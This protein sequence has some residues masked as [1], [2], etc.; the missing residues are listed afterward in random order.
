MQQKNRIFVFIIIFYGSFTYLWIC[1]FVNRSPR[2][3]QMFLL[4]VFSLQRANAT[5]NRSFRSRNSF[6]LSFPH[7]HCLNRLDNT[8]NFFKRHK[9]R[10]VIISYCENYF[11]CSLFWTLNLIFVIETYFRNKVRGS[12]IGRIVYNSIVCLDVNIYYIFI[13]IELIK[14]GNMISCKSDIL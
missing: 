11:N 4:C 3:D 10:K 9:L 2:K 13:A 12:H 7:Y 8:V 1:K 5:M 14:H 6:P